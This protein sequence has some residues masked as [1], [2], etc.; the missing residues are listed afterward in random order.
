MISA[1]ELKQTYSLDSFLEPLETHLI[2][3]ASLGHLSTT[4]GCESNSDYHKD[5]TVWMAGTS[6]QLWRLLANALI[7]LGYDVSYCPA[8]A[9]TKIS[10]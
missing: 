8:K 6:S 3:C 10:W 5:Y 1:H 4:L 2:V 7:K 9:Q